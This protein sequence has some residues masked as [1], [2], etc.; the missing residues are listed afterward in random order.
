[1]NIGSRAEN[2]QSLVEM[3]LIAPILIL[4][5]MGAFDLGRAIYYYNA[6]S[7][8]AREMARQSITSCGNGA[9]AVS[10]T[11]QDSATKSTVVGQLVGV[12]ITTSNITISPT[13]RKYGDTIVVSITIQYTAITPLIGRFLSSSGQLS[14]SA[15]SQ[16]VVQ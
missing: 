2:G 16:M 14:L 12:P 5:L 13:S 7:N 3:A 10:C 11:S 15:H 9:T 4:I 1:M 8:G 6:I